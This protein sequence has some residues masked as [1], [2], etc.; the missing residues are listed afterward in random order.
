MTNLSSR[1][2]TLDLS[3]LGVGRW[4]MDTW[5][6]GPNADRNGMDYVK[7]RRTVTSADKVELKLAPGGGFAARLQKE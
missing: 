3:F 7:A 5:S 1:T 6:D 4:T 2:L